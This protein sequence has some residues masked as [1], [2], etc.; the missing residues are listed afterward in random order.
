MSSESYGKEFR[1][2]TL[3][4]ALFVMIQVCQH[5]EQ[6]IDQQAVQCPC[7]LL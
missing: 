2:P 6:G 3:V 7:C 5:L 1:K 4:S